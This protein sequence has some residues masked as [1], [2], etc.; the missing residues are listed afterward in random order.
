MDETTEYTLDEDDAHE[1]WR[2]FEEGLDGLIESAP[3]PESDAFLGEDEFLGAIPTTHAGV[4]L[5]DLHPELRNRLE[6]ALGDSRLSAIARA[7]SGVRTYEQQK[8]LFATMSPGQAADPDYRGHDGRRG[9]KHMVQDSSWRYAT[10]FE[11]GSFGYAVDVG[12][13]GAEN[14]ALLKAVMGEYGLR[15]TVLRP[16]EPWHF[17]LDPAGPAAPGGSFRFEV[18]KSGVKDVQELLI[19]QHQNMPNTI[20]DPG[21]ADGLIGS[22]TKTAIVAWQAYLGLDADGVWGPATE[23][24]TGTWRAKR[25]ATFKRDSTGD[26]VKEIQ[27]YL[28]ARHRDDPANVSDPGSADGAFGAKT[29]VATKEW[30]SILDLDP[31]GVW[32]PATWKAS[33]HH[34]DAA[35]S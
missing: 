34:D 17:E 7:S 13:W 24:A 31:D 28:A 19:A 16:Y 25:A 33:D 18:T 11:P 8:H 14:W 9:S 6:G 30:Q 23:A 4:N 22:R 20:P 29:E 35:R 1:R 2:A 10:Q 26:V 27:A 12:F 5:R 15:L 32:G 3:A 21:T